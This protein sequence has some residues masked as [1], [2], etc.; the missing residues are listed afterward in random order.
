MENGV[1]NIECEFM[2][3]MGLNKK[4][5]KLKEQYKRRKRIG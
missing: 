3:A 5:E 2:K 1:S 4:S